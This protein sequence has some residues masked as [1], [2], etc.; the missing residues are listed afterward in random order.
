MSSEKNR[1]VGHK[2]GF[3]KRCRVLAVGVLFVTIISFFADIHYLLD[4]TVHFKLHYLI[5]SG[6]LGIGFMLGRSWGWCGAMVIVMSANASEVVSLYYFNSDNFNSDY[7]DS[8]NS[9]SEISLNYSAADITIAHLNVRSSN[10]QAEEVLKWVA[11]N[12]P[13]LI[14]FQEVNAKWGQFLKPL[15]TDYSYQ[16]LVPRED[17]FGIAVYS[18]LDLASVE[19]IDTGPHDLPSVKVNIKVADQMTTIYSTHPLPPIS[20]SYFRSRNHHLNQVATWLSNTDG[21]VVLLGDLNTSAWSSGYK[22]LED[23]SGMENCQQGR[24]ISNSWPAKLSWVGITIDHCLHSDQWKVQSFTIG[25]GVGSDHLP[26]LVGLALLDKD[27]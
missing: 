11:D 22:T 7:V 19:T 18:K 8:D 9:D 21:P 25:S 10:D 3:I 27:S 16:Y 12:S 2:K 1:K 15:E 5:V 13:D 20:D 4:L 24:G 17:N 6:L 14:F 26:L 23:R